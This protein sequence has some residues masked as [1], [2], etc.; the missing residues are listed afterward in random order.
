MESSHDQ[1]EE[2]LR[3]SVSDLGY[4]R[5]TA[6]EHQVEVAELKSTGIE[7]MSTVAVVLLGSVW[8]VNTVSR[9]LDERKGGQVV[10]M[11]PGANLA[12]FRSRDVQYGL[13]V[14]LAFD[15]TVTVRAKD[16]QEKLHAVIECLSGLAAKKIETKADTIAQAARG[17]LGSDFEIVTN[18][19]A[20]K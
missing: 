4:L 5:D 2:V 17:Q 16:S 12:V 1:T 7:P 10:D 9:L 18:P 15:G 3:I 20:S 6:E 19:P 11:R 13:I 14:V 8:A